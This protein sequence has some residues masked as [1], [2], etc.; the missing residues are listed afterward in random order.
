[1]I[2]ARG[3]ILCDGRELEES[4]LPYDLQHIQPSKPNQSLP[5]FDLDSGVEKLH[6]Q[7][8]LNHT[9]GNRAETAR[10]LNIGVATLV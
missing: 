8:V 3:E 4:L 7:R 6:I 1:V 10:L 5:A 2:E 9:H